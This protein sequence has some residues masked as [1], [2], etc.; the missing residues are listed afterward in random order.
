MA[1]D[2]DVALLQQALGAARK[3]LERPGPPSRTSAETALA[4]ENAALRQAREEAETRA[5]QLKAR[6]DE[7]REQIRQQLASY[8]PEA[9]EAQKASLRETE[10]RAMRAEE[11]CELLKRQVP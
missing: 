1:R 11:A 5:G 6:V 10:T 8:P 4:A 7:L 9:F 3:E 2:Q